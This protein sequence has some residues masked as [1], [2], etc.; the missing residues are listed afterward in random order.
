M[1]GEA[2]G[3]GAGETRTYRGKT[4]E[5]LIPKI[6]E[7]LGPE[8]VI[9][10]QRDGLAGGIGGFFQREFVE[11]EAQA[12]APPEPEPPRRFDAYD[13]ARPVTGPRFVPSA[14]ATDGAGEPEGHASQPSSPRERFDEL[15]PACDEEAPRAEPPAALEAVPPGRLVPPDEPPPPE[16]SPSDSFFAQLQAASNLEPDA[17]TL[18]RL[19]K[20]FAPAIEAEEEQSAPSSF[21][22]MVPELEPEPDQAIAE[23]LEEVDDEERLGGRVRPAAADALER[24]LADSGLPA[25][26]A[27]GLVTDVVSHALPFASPRRLKALVRAALAE[28]IPVVGTHTAQRRIVAFVGAGGSGKTLCAA[29]L[30]AAYASGSDLPVACV[31]LRARDGG[32]LIAALLDGTP[33]APEAAAGATEV[34]S[35][36]MQLPG[37]GLLVIDTPTVSPHDPGA[38]RGLASDLGAIAPPGAIEVHLT[39]PATLSAAAAR[40]LIEGCA[41]LGV[42][43]LALTHA[44]ETAHLGHALDLAMSSGLP[45]SYVGRGTAVPGGLTP[46]DPDDL[47]ARVL[48]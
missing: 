6:R 10:R 32:A 47:A 21:V 4:L 24:A 40:E 46:A 29:R 38:V 7:E 17:A 11:V 42:T 16:P 22:P 20:M 41:P 14:P 44:D 34:R 36:L 37:R 2:T 23:R 13:D 27:A 12:G 9:V 43:A 31:A 25:A 5:E 15:P 30:S 1:T 28:R 33:V 3:T 35:A 48:P 39:V 19:E 26:T 8:A 18:D 45:L